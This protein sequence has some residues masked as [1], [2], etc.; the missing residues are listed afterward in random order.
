MDELPVQADSEERYKTLSN[1]AI[2][3]LQAK[4]IVKGASLSSAQAA[5]LANAR[6]ERRR[7]IIK[8]AA[9]E[10]VQ[11]GNFKARYGE[12]AYLA[13][14]AETA[15]I[16]ATTADDPKAIEAARFLLRET[17][18]SD[19]QTAGSSESAADVRGIIHE[20]AG[21]ARAV[22]GC[23]PAVQVIDADEVTDE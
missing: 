7:A 13:A 4:R 22:A 1:G 20:L 15:L 17:G 5:A 23:V 21:L 16:K 6:N 10:A 3:D 2:Y 9:N 11:N 18:E 19:E 8:E 12:F 14:I